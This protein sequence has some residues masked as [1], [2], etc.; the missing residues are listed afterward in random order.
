VVKSDNTVE[1]RP[2]KVD[3]MDETDAVIAQGL[4]AN[5]TVVTDGQLRLVSGASIVAKE[6]GAPGAGKP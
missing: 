6:G 5:E 3:R 1:L 2:V 4:S